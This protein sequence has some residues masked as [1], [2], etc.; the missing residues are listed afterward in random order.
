MKVEANRL[1]ALANAVAKRFSAAGITPQIS[2]EVPQDLVVPSPPIDD[3]VV[4]RKPAMAFRI[5]APDA[6][7]LTGI[8]GMDPLT[9]GPLDLEGNLTPADGRVK[10]RVDSTFGEFDAQLAASLADLQTTNDL[11][12]ELEASGPCA[13]RGTGRIRICGSI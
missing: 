8:L 11:D 1:V 5:E 12:L 13:A 10:V 4:P 2:A 6:E 9:T 3:L 7:H